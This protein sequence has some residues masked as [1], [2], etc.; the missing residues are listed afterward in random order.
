M[1]CVFRSH[2]Q[3]KKKKIPY[4]YGNTEYKKHTNFLSAFIPHKTDNNHRIK[5][6]N[7]NDL[8][9]VRYNE[10]MIFHWFCVLLT[11]R[12]TRIV[13]FKQI[14][15]KKNAQLFCPT[16]SVLCATVCVCVCLRMNVRETWMLDYES[17]RWNFMFIYRN[18][19][20]FLH[21]C[22]EYSRKMDVKR[23]ILCHSHSNT[24]Q[25]HVEWNA[26]DNEKISTK[27]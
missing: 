15:V 21:L 10:A 25:K 9:E 6:E 8:H 18:R 7:K 1:A 26:S 24:T 27:R 14:I 22:K 3:K 17:F 5:D 12:K 19:G 20:L 13:S 11:E 4:D 23:H 16:W 2:N